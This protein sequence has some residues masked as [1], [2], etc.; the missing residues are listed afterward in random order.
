MTGCI[1][2]SVAADFR[3]GRAIGKPIGHDAIDCAAMNRLRIPIVIVA[4]L[5]ASG[6]AP[7]SAQD[8]GVSKAQASRPPIPIGASRS[9]WYFDG[10]DDD[11]DFPTNGFFPGDFAA[12]PSG[13]A[14][15]AAGIFGSNP[16]HAANGYP[17]ILGA[18]HGARHRCW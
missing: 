6:L 14:I 13:A 18:L 4:L 11:R 10:R 7:L 2:N 15:G 1:C 12:N 3:V 17:G 9:I 8:A 16:A 5:A